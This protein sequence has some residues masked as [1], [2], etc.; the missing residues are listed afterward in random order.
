MAHFIDKGLKGPDDPIFTEGIGVISIRKP[1]PA[2]T[3]APSANS[4]DSQPVADRGPATPEKRKD[5]NP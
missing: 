4:A 2:T 1:K 5:K 3:P